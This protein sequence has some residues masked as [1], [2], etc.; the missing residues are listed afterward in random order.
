MDDF[1]PARDI[2]VIRQPTVYLM[3][4]QTV[5]DEELDR[6]LADHGVAWETDTEVAGEHLA[7]IAGRVCYMSFAKPRPGGNRVYLDHIKEV[8]HG[9]F[10]AESTLR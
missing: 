4:R 2:R 3:G 1:D 8:G 7:E 9:S 6:F 5:A 10:S